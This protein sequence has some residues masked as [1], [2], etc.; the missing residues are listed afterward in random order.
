M[1]ALSFIIFLLY[2]LFIFGPTDFLFSLGQRI[3]NL[4]GPFFTPSITVGELAQ[5]RIEAENGPRRIRILIMPGHEPNYGGAEYGEL[6]EREL[7]LSIAI[8]LKKYLQQRKLYDVTLARDEN[9]WNPSLAN[10]FTANWDRIEAFRLSSK[11]EMDRLISAGSIFATS[12]PYHNNARPDVARRLFGINL[13]ADENDIDIVLHLH[14]NDFP[15]K[16]VSLPG[17][18]QGFSIYVPEKQYSNAEA[19]RAVSQSI[20]NRLSYFF[21]SSTMPGEKATVVEDQELIAIGRY[22]TADPV[23]IL[24]EYGYIYEPTL[25][26][27]DIRPLV[28]REYAFQTYLGLE[29]FFNASTSPS[30]SQKASSLL[31]YYFEKNIEAGAPPTAEAFL[32]Q[33]KLSQ[34][35]F[36]P[37]LNYPK[38]DCPLTGRMAKCTKEALS[39]FQKESGIDG[40]GSILGPRTRQKLNK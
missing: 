2:S 28:L 27:P 37:P 13:W 22:N 6:K 21:A 14:L 17:E 8:E 24:I 36:Y 40:D 4:A 38:E 39:N 31:P 7:V 20:A 23:S 11:N 5:K 16:K 25:S 33:M 3:G 29:D 12:T 30:F 1:W 26:S 15:R 10:Y 9:G 19:S 34:L 35:G 32:L 18:Y